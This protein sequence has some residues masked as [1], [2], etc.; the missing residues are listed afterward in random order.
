MIIS[1][2]YNFLITENIRPNDIPIVLAGN[3][4]VPAAL[5]KKY[6]EL[7]KLF[8]DQL[9]KKN[10]NA[11]GIGPKDRESMKQA[12]SKDVRKHIL[13]MEKDHGE[14]KSNSDQ[15]YKPKNGYGFQQNKFLKGVKHLKLA[16]DARLV[17][18]EGKDGKME[19]V[20]TNHAK[21]NQYQHLTK[22]VVDTR[23]GAKAKTNKTE[24]GKKRNDSSTAKPKDSP[25]KRSYMD[26]EREKIARGD[27]DA[28]KAHQQRYDKMMKT[29]DDLN[30]MMKKRQATRS[31]KKWAPIG[32]AGLERKKPSA[33]HRLKNVLGMK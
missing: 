12:A 29:A 21:N 8:I 6:R 9:I 25:P 10:H 15:W 32:S 13:D 31:T 23:E 33:F 14:S 18:F 27:P 5:A 17:W 1:E 24:T 4:K 3:G 16:G 22:Y 11:K 26:R 19:Y 2:F 7:S 20:I 30:K 28:V